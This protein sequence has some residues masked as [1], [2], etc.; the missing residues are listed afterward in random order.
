MIYTHL[1]IISGTL[2]ITIYQKYFEK[3]KIMNFIIHFFF[4]MN[5]NGSLFDFFNTK[6]LHIPIQHDDG[7]RA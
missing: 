4:K 3:F 1:L 6:K 7:C 5:T 2:K